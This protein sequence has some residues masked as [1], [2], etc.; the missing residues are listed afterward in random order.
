MPMEMCGVESARGMPSLRRLLRYSMVV[1]EVTQHHVCQELLANSRRDFWR[2]FRD[3][4]L[5]YIHI[6]L[7]DMV[8]S[9]VFT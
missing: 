5:G 4:Y 3:T 2:I 9:Q 1:V 6:S 7:I 8:Y